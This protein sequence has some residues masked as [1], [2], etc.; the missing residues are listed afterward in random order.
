MICYLIKVNNLYYGRENSING[1][2]LRVETIEDCMFP[3]IIK[4]ISYKT[5]EGAKKAARKIQKQKKDVK[6]TIEE[7]IL[8]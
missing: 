6:I 7:I 1:R 3:Y 5:K 8:K 4:D 2:I